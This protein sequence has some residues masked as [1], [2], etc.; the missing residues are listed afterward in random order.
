M[1]AGSRIMVGLGRL[2]A[3]RFFNSADGQFEARARAGAAPSRP[4]RGAFGPFGARGSE[5]KKLYGAA[6][7]EPARGAFEGKEMKLE[8]LIMAQIERW[9]HA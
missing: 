2:R 4:A 9:R 8:S 3:A 1:A 5:E 7:G 6:G